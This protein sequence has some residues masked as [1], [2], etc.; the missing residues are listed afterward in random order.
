MQSMMQDQ[1]MMPSTFRLGLHIS[2]KAVRAIPTKMPIGQPGLE[3]PS[4]RLSSQ[5][6][7]GFIELAIKTNHD[8]AV[9]KRSLT[10]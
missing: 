8:T 2:T 4:L 10:N 1:R 3:Y 5:V 9:Q 7:V 6:I